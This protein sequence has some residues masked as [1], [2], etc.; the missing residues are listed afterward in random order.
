MLSTDGVGAL[1]YG[2]SDGYAPLREWVSAD[3]AKKGVT[4]PAE[5]IVIANGSQQGTALCADV[6]VV[7]AARNAQCHN[8]SRL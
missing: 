3:L 2:P 6:L 5:R 8:S 1:Q 7:D 4:C